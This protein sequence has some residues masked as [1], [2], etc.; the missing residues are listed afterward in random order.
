[1]THLPRVPIGR[2]EGGHIRLWDGLRQP[3]RYPYPPNTL[4][5]DY[6]AGMISVRKYSTQPLA[7]VE[8]WVE[9]HEKHVTFSLTYKYINVGE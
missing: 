8:F 3:G 6:D 9:N 7:E 2:C 4:C 5:G 1:M